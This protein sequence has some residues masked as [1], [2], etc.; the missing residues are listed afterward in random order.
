VYASDDIRL[1]PLC[2]PA[3]IDEGLLHDIHG[4]Q[5][6]GAVE[7]FRKLG[8]PLP[9][10]SSSHTTPLFILIASAPSGVTIAECSLLPVAIMSSRVTKSLL[11]SF[12]KPVTCTYCY[13]M[14]G[15]SF[16]LE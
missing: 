13:E 2:M 12:G 5:L 4:S 3:K 14:K 9:E 1:E 11:F 6:H 8:S 16:R 15:L 7:M 10:T